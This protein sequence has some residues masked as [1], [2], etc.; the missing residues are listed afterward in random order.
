[1]KKPENIQDVI[2]HDLCNRCG[3]CA[4]L[5]AGRI[6]FSDR[7]GRCVPVIR[8]PLDGPTS[9][10]V[11]Q[12]CSGKGF[13]FPG[14]RLSVFG[15]AGGHPY[16]GHYRDIHIGF[17]T[18]PQ[19]RLNSASGGIISSILTWLLEKK[20]ID[21]AVVLGM[22]EDEPWLARPFIATTREE[23]LQAAQSKYI[24]APVNEILPEIGR[25]EGNLAYVGLPGQVQSI[26]LLQ[27]MDHPWVRPIRYIFGP[28]YGNTLHFSSVNSFLRSFGIRDHTLIRKLY[29]RYGE[30]PGKMRVEL[31]DGRVFE[32]PKFHA[33]YLIPFHILKNSLLCTDL[34]NE[35]T[36]IS[37]GDA[38]APVY[39]ER[40]KGYSM[41]V[42]RSETGEEI[43]KKMLAE[44]R[45]ELQP[46]GE[47]EA[48]EMHSHGYDLKK[49]GTFIRMRFR[50][51]VGK[52][53]PD[54]GYTM[55]GFPVSRY[56]ME[57]VIDALFLILGTGFARW[58]AEKIPPAAIGGVFEK[59][60]KLWK[61]STHGIKRE[62]L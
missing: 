28:F 1:V 56:L 11:W 3:S 53:N 23:I 47:K 42:T 19:I 6:V 59:A 57:I 48:V 31:N 30:W 54:Y 43:I 37:G 44:G 38:W 34:T 41:V 26:R 50:S 29:F 17:S 13:D 45:L 39:E 36:D 52:P 27:Q 32:L 15:D 51:W 40:G 7:T 14:H 25:F 55:K 24:I 58:L 46:I 33:N 35:Y 5:S 49:R 2:R 61:K 9:R 22:S 21:G 16:I 60:R 8:E 18:D 12:A 62:K 20:M 4:G 10:L